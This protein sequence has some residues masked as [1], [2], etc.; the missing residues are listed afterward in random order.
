MKETTA[1]NVEGKQDKGKGEGKSVVDGT[2]G[3]E[4]CEQPERREEH[5]R[6]ADDH[7]PELQGAQ[8]LLAVA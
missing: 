4:V 2:L 8:A 5:G 6:D 7:G 3:V 1:G